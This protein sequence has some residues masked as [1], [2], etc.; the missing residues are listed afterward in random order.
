MFDWRITRDPK[1]RHSLGIS[2]HSIDDATQEA[3]LKLR[4][5]DS[6]TPQLL[7][8]TAINCFRDSDKARRRREGREQQ[9]PSSPSTTSMSLPPR[10]EQLENRAAI[11]RVVRSA[12]LSRNHKCA[13]WAW[14]HDEL[15]E[16]ARRKSI[17]I[18]TA[19]VWAHRAREKLRPFLGKAGLEPE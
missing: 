16:F 9:R 13:L 12:S 7:R 6:V 1:F 5:H 14:V 4:D 19:G 8:T 17:P 2:E 11:L 10:F 18:N 3:W 15:D